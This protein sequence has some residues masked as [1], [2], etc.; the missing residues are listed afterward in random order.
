MRTNLLLFALSFLVTVPAFAQQVIFDPQVC[1]SVIA[2]GAVR[3]A[4]EETHRRY[5]SSINS[6]IG[7]MNTNMGSVVL[8][9]TMIYSSLANVSSALKNGLALKN[10]SVIAADM[11]G[12]IG[13]ALALAKADPPLLLVTSRIAG[14]MRSR[15]LALLNDVSSFIIKEGGN[16]LADYNARDELLRK[17]TQQLQILDSLAYGA[18]KTMF[19]AKQR[20]MLATLTPFAAWVSRDK[21]LVS[22]I[23]ANARYLHQ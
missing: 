15:S 8:A 13:K 9:Q 23:I 10:L 16:V 4:A 5:L 6:N 3:G 22:S 21:A 17:V 1:A 19:W 12:Y 18:W 11:T 14:E 20:G 2:N 7:D